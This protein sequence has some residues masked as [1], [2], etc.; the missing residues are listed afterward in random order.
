M[1]DSVISYLI[2]KIS[3][4]L[5]PSKIPVPTSGSFPVSS[6]TPV[7]YKFQ[8]HQLG[9]D[10]IP[11]LGFSKLLFSLQVTSITLVP[12]LGSTSSFQVKVSNQHLAL[13]SSVPFT[14]HYLIPTKISV[15]IGCDFS[16]LQQKSKLSPK[17]Q[18]GSWSISVEQSEKVIT[19]LNLGT[20]FRKYTLIYVNPSRKNIGQIGGK[21]CEL[22]KNSRIYRKLTANQKKEKQ[23]FGKTSNCW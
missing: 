18:L 10:P 2:E 7:S 20:N 15:H 17:R 13:P 9:T 8:I 5:I 1:L 21:P 19:N 3:L 11:P 23:K 12:H 6:I 22:E 4:A 16:H 14:H